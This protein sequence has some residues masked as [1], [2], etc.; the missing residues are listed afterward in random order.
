MTAPATGAGPAR[1]LAA[2]FTP[3]RTTGLV[4]EICDRIESAVVSGVLTKGQRLPNES[5]F[6]TALGVSA[7]TAREALSRLRAQG[8]VTTARG[9]NGGSFIA[10]D[11][12]ERLADSS[13]RP[14]NPTRVELV[15]LRRHL[16]S[17]A[18]ACAE[19]AAERASTTDIAQLRAYLDGAQE[20]PRE[21]R[22]FESE[23]LLEV[24]AVAR[25]A[26][27]TRDLL[28]IR[29]ES[30]PLVSEAAGDA[31]F[32]ARLLLVRESVIAAIEAKDGAAARK[33][34]C[35]L[36]SAPIDVQ[37]DYDPQG[38]GDI[39]AAVAD[40]DDYVSG[41]EQRLREWAA[42]LGR[43]L[44]LYG[45]AVTG[46]VID[47]L[48]KP[49]VETLVA[50]DELGLIGAGFVANVGVVGGDRTH[51]A[52]WQGTELDRADVLANFS[53]HSQTRYLRAEWFRAPLSTGELEVTG[54]YVD[55]LC[56]D[57][58]IVTF[59]A[60]VTWT[61]E[62]HI[63][64]VVGMDVTTPTLER[65]I[66]RSLRSI[67]EATL[68]NSEGRAVV[69]AATDISSGDLVPNLQDLQRWPVGSRFSIVSR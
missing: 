56:T 21:W 54:P 14:L 32:R 37:L 62:P 55:L 5:E 12:P 3:V 66:L 16:Q 27:L 10:N 26:R 36:V 42:E 11:A 67:G 59:T 25:S 51:F 13:R 45:T 53:T 34:I 49:E 61:H 63:V 60:P 22:L 40:I 6:A 52:W 19:I 33:Y 1:S 69:S 41:I 48:V 57:D 31:E 47:R 17:I 18:G 30:A 43:R 44:D 68:V 7:V 8:I 2:V 24:A 35:D 38:A 39:E 23:F 20:D 46:A 65:R 64:G 28:R 29:T 15:D 4:D 9:R 50:Q 58:Y